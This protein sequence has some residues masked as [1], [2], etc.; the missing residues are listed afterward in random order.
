MLHALAENWWLIL[1]RGFAA[2]V[3]GVLAF[4]WPGL[5]LVTLVLFYGAFALV[6]GVLSL[7]AAV[8]GGAK[9]VPTWWLVVVGI[10]GVAAG[11]VTF[12]WPG[13]TALLLVLFIGSW[14]IVQGVFQIIGAIQLR[15]EIDNEWTLILAGLLSVLFGA[16]VV[17]APG[18]G[19]LGLVWAIAAYAIVFG[20]L[21]VALAFRLRKHRKSGGA[22]TATAQHPSA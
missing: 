8:R 7:W 16:I 10:A 19:A 22:E 14:A 1:L 3:F 13:I 12:V 18:A 20:I 15:K 6:D 21:L 17:I 2:I 4:I 9:P 11:I 5:T